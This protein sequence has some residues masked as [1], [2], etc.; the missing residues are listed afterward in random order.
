MPKKKK[1]TPEEGKRTPAQLEQAVENLF[2]LHPKRRLAPEQIARMLND[3]NDKDA[4]LACL[5]KLQANGKVIPDEKGKYRSALDAAAAAPAAEKGWHTAEGRVDMTR[6]GAAY[7]VVEQMGKDIFVP[8]HRISNALDGDRVRVKWRLS[9]RGKPEGSVTHIVTRSAENFVG[10]YREHKG[11]SY[12]VPDKQNMAI[13]ILIENGGNGGAKVGDKVLVTVTQWHDEK[14][15]NPMGRVSVVLGEQGTSD[16][17]MKS[18]LLKFGFHWLFPEDVMAENEAVSDAITE[19]EVALRR[20]FRSTATFTIDPLTAR[21]FDDALSYKVL[22]NQNIEIGV[23]IA[24]VSHFVRPGTALDR[25]ALRRSTSVYLV[26]RVAP[27]LPE[28]LSNVVCSLRPHEDRLCFSAVFEFTPDGKQIVSEWFGRTVIH[29]QRRF[30]Y[31]EAQEVIET[32][33]GDF[34]AELR[35]LNTFAKAMRQA[36]MEKGA[37]NFEA[38]ELQFRLDENAKPVEVQVK[39]RKDAHLLIEEF[40][41]LAN[42]QVGGYIYNAPAKRGVPEIPFVYR[43]HDLPDMDRL[44][45]FG[46]FVKEFGYKLVI[47]SPEHIA[48]SLNKLMKDAADSEDIVLFQQQAIR[49]MAK[50]VY[51]T[52]NI[53]HYGLAFHHYSHFT[54]PIRRYADMIAHRILAENLNGNYYRANKGSLEEQCKHISAQERKAMEAERESVKYKQVEF[55]KDHIGEVFPGIVAGIAEHGIFVELTDTLCEGR[56]T[57]DRMP[58]SFVVETYKIKGRRTGMTLR[59]GESIKVRVVAA[60][61]QRRQ[62]DLEL[63]TDIEA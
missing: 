29:S 1:V 14:L 58:E 54:S 51:S 46:R 62:I 45:E 12:V 28:R 15:A 26:D 7:V 59:M 42:Q 22:E 37:I 52:D 34:A 3:T 13:D 53:G 38:P 44:A 6:N 49:C 11:E 50:A 32:Q 36:R 24:D 47:D 43:I 23:H 17:E 40:M 30:T 57:F 63:V 10:V 56:I 9:S 2:Q 5:A 25:E 8:P 48:A 41:L 61:L 39:E 19:E 16:I 31:E 55:I 33:Q 60:D 18:I 21:D 20:D 35:Q 4:I 27:M